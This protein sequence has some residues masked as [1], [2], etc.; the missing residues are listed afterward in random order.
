MPRV[1]P[2]TQRGKH[3]SCAAAFASTSA[4]AL[5]DALSALPSTTFTQGTQDADFS[6]ALG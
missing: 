5:A 1:A 2:A 4:A 6:A 3:R